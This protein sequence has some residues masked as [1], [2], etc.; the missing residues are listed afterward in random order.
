VALSFIEVLHFDNR[1]F[2]PF[3][4]CDLDLEPMT[5]TYELDP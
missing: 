4:S 3:C 5:F 1:D 2:R